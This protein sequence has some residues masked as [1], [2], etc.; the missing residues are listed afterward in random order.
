MTQRLLEIAAKLPNPPFQKQAGTRAAVSVVFRLVPKVPLTTPPVL[1][2]NWN[3]ESLKGFLRKWEDPDVQLLY[4]KR[5]IYPGDRHSGHIAFPGGKLELGESPYE[6]AVRETREE[7]GLHLDNHKQFAY[8]G[9]LGEVNPYSGSFKK[10]NMFLSTH[11]FLQT[12]P[13]SINLEPNEEV[14]SCKWVS[15]EEFCEGFKHNFKP[16]Y[17]EYPGIPFWLSKYLKS[18]KKIT[19]TVAGI[20]LPP[21][22]KLLYEKETFSESF[23]LWGVTYRRTRALMMLVPFELRRT[24]RV[25]WVYFNLDWPYSLANWPLKVLDTLSLERYIDFYKMPLYMGVGMCLRVL[26]GL[27]AFWALKT[28]IN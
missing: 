12:V 26:L 11:V 25:S 17:C 6:A 21:E 19:G 18:S 24:R 16:K 3:I 28:C 20:E 7:V 10:I 9:W 2:Q 1:A 15:L 27:S 13:G 5:S 22:P 4:I 8:L 14:A 23:H